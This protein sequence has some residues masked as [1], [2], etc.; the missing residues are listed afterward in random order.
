[1]NAHELA[2]ELHL[3]SSQRKDLLDKA[4]ALIRQQADSIK[5]LEAECKALRKQINELQ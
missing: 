4:V 5:L 2:N 1:M 3:I